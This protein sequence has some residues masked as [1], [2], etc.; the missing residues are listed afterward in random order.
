MNSGS[1]TTQQTS[2]MLTFNSRSGGISALMSAQ[3]GS[4]AASSKPVKFVISRP[5]RGIMLNPLQVKVLVP[6]TGRSVEYQLSK[7]SPDTSGARPQHGVEDPAVAQALKKAQEGVF[8]SIQAQ[9]AVD[10]A[11]T[12]SMS[13]HTHFD[14]VLRLNGELLRAAHL[15]CKVVY[16]NVRGELKEMGP[17]LLHVVD[18][19]ASYRLEEMNCKL[20]AK[21]GHHHVYL[22]VQLV[23]AEAA[24]APPPAAALRRSEQPR[25]QLPT[26]AVMP[27]FT[28]QWSP[29]ATLR[30][31]G[32]SGADTR[33]V[34]C[35]PQIV[36]LCSE[37]I[38]DLLE[39]APANS[40][41]LVLQGAAHSDLV[42]LARLTHP[43]TTYGVT[44]TNVQQVL[45]LASRFR[46]PHL[47]ATAERLL[48]D[49]LAGG[50]ADFGRAELIEMA[51]EYE[52][53][54]LA[55]ALQ[56]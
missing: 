22:L 24:V 23:S 5:I 7:A 13:P 28:V 53:Q 54:T 3:G 33:P 40:G 20:S 36:A 34:Y 48:C 25:V 41:E 39:A 47:L 18:Q 2:S 55:K 30:L 38:R 17:Y 37:A 49:C 46:V 29:L 50:S 35:V 1:T 56:G 43:G 9:R 4:G 15:L 44:P 26:G 14:L 32:D 12:I 8:V 27:D 45:L 31:V 52:L 10:E 11:C 19:V 51:A 21:T 42:L 16:Q 6:R